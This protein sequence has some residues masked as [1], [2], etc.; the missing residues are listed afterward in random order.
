MWKEAAVTNFMLVSWYL[1]EGTEENS[2]N[3][4]QDSRTPG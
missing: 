4:I 2:E 3:L 1:S